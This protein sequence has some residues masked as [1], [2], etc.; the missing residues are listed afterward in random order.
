VDDGIVTAEKAKSTLFLERIASLPGGSVFFA[1]LET[2]ANGKVVIPKMRCNYEPMTGVVFEFKN[3]KLENFKAETGGKYFQEAMAPY[4]GPKDM[5]GT[6]SIGLNPAL[7]VMEN[8]GD[9]RPG[10]AA[11]MVSITVGDNRLFGGTNM[12]QGSMDFPLTKTTVEIDGKVVVKEGE[13]VF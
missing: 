9:Y 1:P 7:K 11:G 10:N 12:T 5:F 2:S 6:F 13:L 4:S 3:G 8:P